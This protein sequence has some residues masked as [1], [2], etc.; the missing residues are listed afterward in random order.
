MTNFNLKQK[1]LWPLTVCAACSFVSNFSMAE[2]QHATTPDQVRDYVNKHRSEIVRQYSEFLSLPDVKQD[3]PAL[4]KVADYIQKQL[5]TREM[6][7]EQLP[8]SSGVPI[9]Y[10]EKTV[11]NADK[12]ILFYMHYDGEPV[13][14]KDWHQEDPFKPVV[15]TESLDKKGEI[16]KDLDNAE[17]QDNWRIYARAAAD[18]KAPIQAIISALDATGSQPKHNIKLIIEGEE[19]NGGTGVSE[20][21]KQYPEKL[22]S[23]ILVMLDGPQHPSGK[24]TIFY[25][26]R[27]EAALEMTVYTGKQGMHSGNYGNFLPDANV[28]M[29]QLIASMVEPSG[30]VKIKGWYKDVPPFTEQDKAMF[31][32]VPDVS[33]KVAEDFGIGSPTSFTSTFEEALNLPALSV[34]TLKGG[35]VGNVIPA[36]S[37]AQFRFRIVKETNRDDMMQ[38]VVDHIKSQGYYVVDKA[39]DA[40]TLYKHPRVANVKILPPSDPIASNPWRTDPNQPQAKALTN[41]LISAWGSELVRLRQLGSTMP[42]APFVEYLK[43]PVVG[44][45]I[46]NF[47]NNQHSADENLRLGNL[48]DGIYTISA[49]MLK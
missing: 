10:A 48:Y 24:P 23:D 4:K 30:K 45:S 40:E 36:S 37:Y 14:P 19:E 39:P 27:G 1:L 43:V 21:L 33:K 2:Q 28:R 9:V 41:A 7:V 5:E 42:A 3:V 20:V 46:V 44:V 38:R 18:D 25:G 49:M 34:H 13:N 12:T 15:R 31:K 22:R 6:K 8:T 47:D 35:E 29:S 32:A 17:I 16:V 11:P 26:T